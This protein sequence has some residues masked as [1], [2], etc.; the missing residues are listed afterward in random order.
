MA[1]HIVIGGVLVLLLGG[2]AYSR[3]IPD[4]PEEALTPQE[5]FSH[6]HGLAVDATDTD[7]LYIATHEGL[8]VLI[9]EKDL[10]RVGKKKDDLMGFTA[11]PTKG[12]TFFSSGHS[13]LVGNIGFQKTEDGGMTWKKISDGL[14]G[15]VDFHALTVSAANPNIVYGSFRGLQ[16]SLDGGNSWEMAKGEI[17][18]FSLSSDPLRENVVY[19]TT[20]SGVW[21]SE[22]RGD[23]WKSLSSQL[24]GGAASFFV[25]RRDGIALTFSEKLGGLGK[26]LDGGITWQRVNESFGGHTVLYI[27]FS[28]TMSN[29]VYALTEQNSVYKSTDAG[30]TWSKVR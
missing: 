12:G 23:S 18:P 22:D 21:V 28:S 4:T 30:D 27:A 2:F 17:A 10:F 16:R 8:Y 14:G 29:I 6:S 20:R 1:K 11:H 9:G 3:I 19:A 26:S 13:A 24:E 7:K 25:L 15:P 5:S